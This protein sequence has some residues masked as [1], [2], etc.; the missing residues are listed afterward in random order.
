M[1]VNNRE[2][3]LQHSWER[4]SEKLRDVVVEITPKRRNILRR[5]LLGIL[6]YLRSYE[7]NLLVQY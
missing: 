7:I 1:G 6:K 2:I 3:G 4:T 5:L